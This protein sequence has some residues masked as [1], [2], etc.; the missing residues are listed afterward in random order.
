MSEDKKYEGLS[1][2]VVALHKDMV[3]QGD[4]ATAS[5]LLPTSVKVEAVGIG[6]SPAV[7]DAGQV[8][9]EAAADRAAEKEED[10]AEEKRDDR[11]DAKRASKK[12]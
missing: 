10:A 6:A 8:A 9:G 1:P 4:F 5:M 11:T 12:K 7:A 2:E 3:A